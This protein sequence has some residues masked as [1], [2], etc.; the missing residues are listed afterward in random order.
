MTLLLSVLGTGN[1]Y[2]RILCTYNNTKNTRNTDL[3]KAHMDNN[4]HKPVLKV[5]DTKKWEI[6]T[7][8]LHENHAVKSYVCAVESRPAFKTALAYYYYIFVL[9]LDFRVSLVQI[10][11][12][13]VGLLRHIVSC[14]HTF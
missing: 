2:L 1:K 5:N 13:G 8:A 6:L 7:S 4:T 11:A 9:C 12:Q 3:Y 14:T 10:R